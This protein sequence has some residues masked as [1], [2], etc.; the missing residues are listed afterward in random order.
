[1]AEIGAIFYIEGLG[2]DKKAL[3]RAAEQIVKELKKENVVKVKKV[4]VADILENPEEE[5]LKYSVM[6]EAEVEGS[7]DGI[8][9]AVMKYSP[10]VVEVL[11]P[12]RLEINAKDLMKTLGEVSLFMGKLMDQF[13]GLAAYPPLDK[14]PKP[15]I[16]YSDEE[17]EEFIVDERNVRYQFV[18]ETY[19]K[20]K[21]TI[22]ETIMKA[23]YLE[24]CRINKF[25]VQ[26]QEEKEDKVYALVAAELLSSFETLTQLTAKYAPVAISILEPEIIDVT[27]SELQNA[28]TDL[29]GFVHELIHRPLKKKLIEQDTIK[30]GLS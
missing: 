29:A 20:D 22:E 18:I 25:I 7:F 24:G 17:I 13:G 11:K 19:G 14:L 6:I 4:N 21:G 16:G 23:F 27:A 28:L 26:V 5:L 1:M 15:R 12:G 2:N 9:K 30:F 8:V 10:V 3:E